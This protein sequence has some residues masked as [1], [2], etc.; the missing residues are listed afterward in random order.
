M[1]KVTSIHADCVAAIA[2]W[3]AEGV[4]P[5]GETLPIEP[6]ICT[7]LGVSRTVVRE[8]VK[9]L[10]AKGL[11]TTGPRV[12]TRVQPKANWNL[13]DPDVIE[14]R[15]AAGID[16]RLLRDI[17]D[18]RLTFEP[19]ACVFASERADSGDLARIEEAYLAMANAVHGQGRYFAADIDFHTAILAAAHNQFFAALSPLMIAILRVSMRLSVRNRV[20][21]AASLPHHRSVADA[22]AARDANAAKSAMIHLIQVARLDIERGGPV[23]RDFI[24][25]AA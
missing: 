14:W 13:Y 16:E 23:D 4:Y 25:G 12:G 20:G 8:A 1:P 3:I 9:T 7:E 2:G 10:V 6:T 5:P 21:A 15:F 17:L 19:A 11:L 22:I 18:L 24:A